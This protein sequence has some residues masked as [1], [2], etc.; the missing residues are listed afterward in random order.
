VYFDHL[1]HTFHS[2]GRASTTS[3]AGLGGYACLRTFAKISLQDRGIVCRTQA[4]D[5]YAASP[6]PT[7]VECIRAV[8]IGRNCAELETPGAFPRATAA[9]VGNPARVSRATESKAGTETRKT[10]TNPRPKKFRARNAFIPSCFSP[11][12]FRFESND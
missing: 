6:T 4:A 8:P 3:G 9:N 2:P 5:E 12:S 1:S 11:A 7:V 10:E